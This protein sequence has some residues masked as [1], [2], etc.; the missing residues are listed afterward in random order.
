M[1]LV[2]ALLPFKPSILARYFRSKVTSRF[3]ALDAYSFI[4]EWKCSQFLSLTKTFKVSLQHAKLLTPDFKDELLRIV[5]HGRPLAWNNM[6]FHTGIAYETQ[7]RTVILLVC[8]RLT[9]SDTTPTKSIK[10]ASSLYSC[11][12]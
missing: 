10:C 2:N 5:L 6:Y 3:E 7:I 1:L 12:R 9:A 11:V 8:N 4:G